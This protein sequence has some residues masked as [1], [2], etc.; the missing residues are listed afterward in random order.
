MDIMSYDKET[1]DLLAHLYIEYAETPSF[2][3][4]VLPDGTVAVIYDLL[5]TRSICLG[6]DFDSWTRR[7]CFKNRL[8]AEIEFE[9]LESENDIPT[10]YVARRPQWEDHAD[11]YLNELHNRPWY[12]ELEKK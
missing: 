8:L 3:P 6:V 4:R 1:A 12:K 7:F 10:G 9:K 11:P 5:T 2:R